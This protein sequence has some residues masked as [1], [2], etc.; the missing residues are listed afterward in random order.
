MLC[1]QLVQLPLRNDFTLCSSRGFC[2]GCAVCSRSGYLGS[3]R[4][5]K[6]APVV[7]EP[8]K[9]MRQE[10]CQD[11]QQPLFPARERLPLREP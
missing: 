1:R 8:C 6:A 11:R 7:A 9:N 10:L 5:D 2:G 3:C 4:G